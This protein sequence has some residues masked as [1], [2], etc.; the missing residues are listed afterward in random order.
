M[1]QRDRHGRN[2]FGRRQSLLLVVIGLGA[3]T[4]LGDCAFAQFLLRQDASVG[5][6][7]KVRNSCFTLSNTQGEAVANAATAGNLKLFS[8]FWGARPL[9]VRDSLY[10]DGFEDC[11]P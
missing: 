11:S 9:A 10:S 6:G 2:W 5:T 4:A 3:M 7:G 8:G 1:S